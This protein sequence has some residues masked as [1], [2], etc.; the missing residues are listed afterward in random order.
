MRIDRTFLKTRRKLERAELVHLRALC[1]EQAERIEALEQELERAVDDANAADSMVRVYMDAY[2]ELQ[3][4]VPA[5]VTAPVIGLTREG[6]MGI[7]EGGA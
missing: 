6:E 7:V 4:R 1:A 3:E 5:G 2:H